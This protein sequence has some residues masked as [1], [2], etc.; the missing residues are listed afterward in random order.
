M[1]RNRM[2]NPEFFLDEELAT[3]SA[4]G[5]LLY[6][7]LWGICDDTNATLPNR[8]DWIKAQIFPY[9]AVNVSKLLSEIRSIGKII[10]F[11]E[12]TQEWWYLKNFTK[13]QKV[14]HPSKS[15][16]PIFNEKNVILYEPSDNTREDS[17]RIR[18]GLAL[19]R[20]EENR[21]EIELNSPPEG[22]SPRTAGNL[23]KS[24]YLE[25]LKGRK[26]ASRAFSPSQLLASEISE[27]GGWRM[28]SGCHKADATVSHGEEGTSFHVCMRCGKATDA[29]KLFRVSVP[30]LM[31]MM[32]L[33]GEQ[34]VRACWASAKDSKAR[35]PV[36]LFLSLYGKVKVS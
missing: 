24:G 7:G 16:Y 25:K 20:T 6:E 10:L 23:P 19:N 27:W 21:T 17:D 12:G 30:Q 8:P 3:T 31:G 26:R 32:K 22:I 15:K 28:S 11:R 29:V 33:K 5:R 14:D 35:D 13:H 36:A 2:L 18:G 9:N 4:Y 1:A 34:F